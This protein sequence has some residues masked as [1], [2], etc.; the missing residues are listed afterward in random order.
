VRH[1]ERPGFFVT[2]LFGY[3]KALALRSVERAH[4]QRVRSLRRLPLEL[5]RYEVL[6]FAVGA[7]R[8]CRDLHTGS[9]LREG[10]VPG[11]LRGDPGLAILQAATKAGTAASPFAD[12]GQSS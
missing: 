6:G 1:G 10:L 3:P 12:F 9:G 8:Y 2:A 5:A 4:G 7:R 11:P